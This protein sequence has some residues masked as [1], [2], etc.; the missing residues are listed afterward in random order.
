MIRFIFDLI[1]F[2]G[3]FSLLPLSMIEIKYFKKFLFFN[4]LLKKQII[5]SGPIPIKIA[6]FIINFQHLELKINKPNYLTIYDELFDNV[7]NNNN[8][9]NIKD[10]TIINSGSICAIYLHSNNKEI[11]KKLHYKSTQS[12][13]FYFAIIKW[14]F[15]IF[16]IPIN[17]NDFSKSFFNQFSMNFES[18]MQQNFYNLLDNKLIQIPKIIKYNDQEIFM[19]Y[20]PSISYRKSNLSII[21]T[22][23]HCN[24]MAIFFKHMYLNGIIHLDIH[25]GN[26]GINEN[27][28]VIYDFGYS[29]KLFD[30]LDEIE[31]KIYTDLMFYFLI[32][33]MEKIIKSIFTHFISP[34]LTT[35]IEDKIISELIPPPE[36][37][38]DD[39]YLLRKLIENSKIYQY[40]IH[41]NLY[42]I[43]H[44]FLSLKFMYN[45]LFYT[46]TDLIKDK[47]KINAI[48]K[49]THE[50]AIIHKNP[51]YN[52]VKLFNNRVIDY[53]K[54]SYF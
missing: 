15:Y 21:K 19:E 20:L 3:I 18:E 28:I 23:K 43:L 39:S 34:R 24:I 7:Y 38:L 10:F 35:N 8:I 32:K 37:Y 45:H 36:L 27:G 6:Q 14:L 50:N 4:K 16:K 40:K 30:P 44:S 49:A 2:I 33:D 1:N 11:I 17:I 22:I 42:Y 5:K 41:I 9:N 31:T 51:Y 47:I 53:L 48:N 26:W 46:D 13:T 52:S 12:T 25:D 29:L 54:K